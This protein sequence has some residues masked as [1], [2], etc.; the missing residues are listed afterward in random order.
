[1]YV[2][3]Y[4]W[5]CTVDLLLRLVQA[6]ILKSEAIL[7]VFSGNFNTLKEML[8]DFMLSTSQQVFAPANENIHRLIWNFQ[9]EN[10]TERK[11]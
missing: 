5:K 7:A 11:L 8:Q 9:S 10:S 6:A 4:I 2:T 1:M 3:D